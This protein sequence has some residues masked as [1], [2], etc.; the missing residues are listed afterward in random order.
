MVAGEGEYEQL[1]ELD[2]DGALEPLERRQPRF[3]LT[4][5]GETVLQQ[6]RLAPRTRL[7][8]YLLHT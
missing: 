1:R 3:R 4:A 8:A 2:T 6:Q 5:E 7:L